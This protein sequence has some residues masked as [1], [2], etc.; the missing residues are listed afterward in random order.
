MALIPL[1]ES[2]INGLK[3]RCPDSCFQYTIAYESTKGMYR[4][5]FSSD[6]D[7]S[8]NGRLVSV[9]LACEDD[10]IMVG[11]GTN[12]DE[13]S[14]LYIKFC[15]SGAIPV[16]QDSLESIKSIIVQEVNSHVIG[17]KGGDKTFM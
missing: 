8:R 14:L 12:G 1:W 13:H 10:G 3:S 16:L 11:L 5:A 17:E 4:V 2:G 9:E 7:T 15:A 6:M